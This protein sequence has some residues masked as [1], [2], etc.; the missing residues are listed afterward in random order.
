MRF[1]KAA[2]PSHAK[3]VNIFLYRQT[4]L[5]CPPKDD[6]I[7]YIGKHHE[8]SDM[9]KQKF[10]AEQI[11]GKLH[12]ADVLQS[13]GKTIAEITRQLAISDMTYYKWRKEYGGLRIDQAKRLKELE[14]ENQKLRK[15]VAD[16]SIDVVILKEAARGNF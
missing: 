6:P 12:E 8:R 15:V 5:A 14:H 7:S 3:P 2:L 9:G 16:L 1:Y 4:I 10:T 13:Q 11:M